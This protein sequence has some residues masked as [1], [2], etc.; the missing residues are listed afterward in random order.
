FSSPDVKPVTVSSWAITSPKDFLTTALSEL[1]GTSGVATYGPPYT[2]VAGAGQNIL[3]GV[4]VQRAPGGHIPIDTAHASVL[5]P[6]S[7]PAH[8]NARLAAAL[9]AYERAAPAQRQAWTQGFAKALDKG[10]VLQT[11]RRSPAAFGPVP[12]LMADL[13]AMARSGG[14][15]GALV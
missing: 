6:L 4:S 1:N 9:A 8:T 5:G 12:V 10:T 13:L 14:L 2:H 3:G 11:L 15:D 7:I